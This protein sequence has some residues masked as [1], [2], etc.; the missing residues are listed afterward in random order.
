MRTGWLEINGA[1]V[2]INCGGATSEFH[3][4]SLP[5]HRLHLDCESKHGY[6]KCMGAA[7]MGPENCTCETLTSAEHDRCIDD[8]WE[9][10]S[11]RDGAACDDC[12]FRAGSPENDMLDTIAAQDIPFRCH[13]GMP[14]KALGGVPSKDSYCPRVDADG[15]GVGF[16]VCAGWKRAHAALKRKESAC[17]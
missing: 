1:L 6:P 16:P 7:A 17:G 9:A 4:E 8:A 3:D 14:V 15:E 10:W 13:K 11:K 5:P 2:H 12:A